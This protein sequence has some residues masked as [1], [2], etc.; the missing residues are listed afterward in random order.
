[1]PLAERRSI[2][3]KMLRLPS[4]IQLGQYRDQKTAGCVPGLA[5]RCEATAL[6]RRGVLHL[7]WALPLVYVSVTDDESLCN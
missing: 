4:I 6:P 7:V 2:V 1:M 3:F 5:A